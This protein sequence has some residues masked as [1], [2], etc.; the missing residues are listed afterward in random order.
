MAYPERDCTRTLCPL[1]SW[2]KWESREAQQNPDGYRQEYHGYCK[3]HSEVSEIMGRIR[4]YR[5]L[6]KYILHVC[7]K[8]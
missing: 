6:L 2:I 3:T 4:Q 7:R 5:K 1:L 8:W